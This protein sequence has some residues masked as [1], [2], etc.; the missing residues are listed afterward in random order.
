MPWADGSSVTIPN[1]YLYWQQGFA[2]VISPSVTGNQ[3]LCDVPISHRA[4]L[5]D[6]GEALC[7]GAPHAQ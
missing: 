1:Q 5:H 3:S 2:G 6:F 7:D 4:L